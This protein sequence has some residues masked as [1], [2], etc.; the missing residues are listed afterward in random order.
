MCQKLRPYVGTIRQNK[1]AR[2]YHG[3]GISTELC[4]SMTLMYL[5]GGHF[6][7]IIDMHGVGKSAFYKLLWSTIEGINKVIKMD[8]IPIKNHSALAE[9]S[10]GFERLN[11]GALVGCVGAIDGIAIEIC[12]LTPWDTFFPKQF[13]NRKGFFSINCQAICDA[14]LRFTWCSLKSPGMVYD[15]FSLV[16]LISNY[17]SNAIRYFFLLRG[18]P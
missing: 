11:S 3:S 6:L 5:G 4:L 16:L 1:H 15:D 2:T 14:N 8:G 17:A 13:M 12:K 9:L 18:D 10:A 7:D